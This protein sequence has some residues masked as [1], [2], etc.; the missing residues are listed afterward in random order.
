[1]CGV[2]LA[3]APTLA[4]PLPG[5]SEHGSDAAFLTST[6]VPV[7][8]VHVQV[9]TRFCEI[10][11]TSLARTFPQSFAGDATDDVA[12]VTDE[13]VTESTTSTWALNLILQVL[14]RPSIRESLWAPE[15]DDTY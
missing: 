5:Q 14:G 7:S 1:M 8:S 10:R 4:I 11:P 3:G 6:V 9:A 15:T 13:S 12:V 2:W